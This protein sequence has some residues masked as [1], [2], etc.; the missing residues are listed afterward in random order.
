M[1]DNQI[2]ALVESV[3]QRKYESRTTELKSSREGNPRKFYDTL[4]SFSNTSGG[5]IIFGIN[6]KDDYSICGVKD[7]A[8]L[9][10]VVQEVSKEMEPVVRPTITPF[11]YAEGIDLLIVEVEEMPFLE[12]PCYYKPLG[13]MQ[14]SF[15]RTGDGDEPMTEFEIF[16]FQMY[17]KQSK[18]ELETF[19]GVTFERS[20]DSIKL[21][22]YL[23]K[24]IENKPN[25]ANLP[26]ETMLEMLGLAVNGMPT[27]SCLL[28]FGRYP[29]E[30]APMMTINCVK[31]NGD[32]YVSE[33]EIHE[34]FLS[35]ASIT[36][37]ITQMY[38]GAFRFIVSNM[39]TSTY[40]DENGNRN[41]RSEYPLPAIRELLL[42]ALIHRDY[43]YLVRNIPISVII[44]RNRIEISNPGS[45]LGNYKVE[46]LGK[47]YLP[48]RN[49]FLCRNAEDLLETENRHSGVLAVYQSMKKQGLFPPLFESNRGFFKVT[50]FNRSAKEYKNEAFVERVL[51]YCYTPRSKASLAS[52]FGFAEDKA[53][54][55]YNAY[56]KPLIQGGLLFLT[57]PES[58]G[59]KYQRITSNRAE[60]RK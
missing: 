18:T 36:G 44:Y 57:I 23:A 21:D 51:N 53:T 3:R 40:I 17:K 48:I 25:F 59:S 15:I 19:E 58:P 60:L 27:L 49:A 4:S 35:N 1:D 5:V 41:D 12:K 45:I 54:Y 24:A 55:F 29:Q 26:K 20:V 11:H 14:G 50:L 13:I 9:Q 32:E 42:N 2:S 30:V 22:A 6:E 10:R 46:D 28:L 16:Q 8:E 34:R 37:T 56:I 39:N 38:T 31:V 7:V 52:Y 47:E 43:S 33:N